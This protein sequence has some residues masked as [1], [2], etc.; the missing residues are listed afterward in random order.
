MVASLLLPPPLLTLSF[1]QYSSLKDLKDR[2]SNLSKSMSMNLCEIAKLKEDALSLGVRLESKMNTIK[3]ECTVE[4]SNLH[5]H[6][7]G[8]FDY[9]DERM[10]LIFADR[11]CEIDEHLSSTYEHLEDK[12]LQ[13]TSELDSLF[14]ARITKL[15]CEYK[16]FCA[17]NKI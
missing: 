14:S 5:S 7:D 16:Y 11:V 13:K 17:G 9:V 10:D 8:A 2:G 3:S 6:L 12:I 1:V 4:F 15:E